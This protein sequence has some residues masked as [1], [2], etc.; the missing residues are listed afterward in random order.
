MKIK[1]IIPLHIEQGSSY[2]V[3]K[4]EEY[5]PDIQA[6]L[7]G[8]ST[9]NSKLDR[10]INRYLN[11][12]GLIKPTG[13]LNSVGEKVRDTGYLYTPNE[14]K[15]TIWYADDHLLEGH[16]IIYYERELTSSSS[17]RALSHAQ[18][19]HIK[20]VER[21]YSDKSDYVKAEL[22]TDNIS[23]VEHRN[24]EQ[25]PIC[26]IHQLEIEAGESHAV[27]YYIGNLKRGDKKSYNLRSSQRAKE[28][29]ELWQERLLP[30]IAQDLG[31]EWHQLEQRF[32]LE[33]KMAEDW[34]GSTTLKHFTL[35][36]CKSNSKDGSSLELE[37]VGVMPLNERE[38]KLW[39]DH[40]LGIEAQQN[41]LQQGDLE[42][43]A[44]FREEDAF[45]PYRAH[46][47]TPAVTEL[48]D[49]LNEQRESYWHLMAPKDLNPS[50]EILHYD[51]AVSIVKG[52]NYSMEDIAKKLGLQ[53]SR[54]V[55]YC[56]RYVQK[57]WQQSYIA[58]LLQA[59]KA[60]Q[61]LVIT[62]KEDMEEIRYL[63]KTYLEQYK[64]PTQL[65]VMDA[66]QIFE[67][68]KG[69]HDRCIVALD[70]RGNLKLWTSTN[71]LTNF[72]LAEGSSWK[73]FGPQSI[74]KCRE[75]VTFTPVELE[76]QA[77]LITYVRNHFHVK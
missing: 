7:Q 53:S 44:S 55:V 50:A 31:C 40:L 4:E 28:D 14:G 20:S 15:Y 19:L 49:R 18:K 61:S 11:I 25:E 56:D 54:L 64:G 66:S 21:A 74:I 42:T 60:E 33:C 35:S 67:Y 51:K 37:H 70:T 58:G 3:L 76:T 77:E 52:Q 1:Y 6:Y 9:G 12:L 75:S 46:L 16:R 59:V 23:V 73:N 13:E 30:R 36:C 5:R 71:G 29:L 48:A 32:A 47:V 26:M 10:G 22:V 57:R 8:K 45:A 63:G 41:Y 2:M 38:A 17:S 65:E 34:G 68:K 24:K 39:F 62:Q 43:L 27:R 72:E 69:I